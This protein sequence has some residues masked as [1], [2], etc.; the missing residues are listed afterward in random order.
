VGG[1]LVQILLFFV[2]VA[3][4]GVCTVALGY[5]L[6]TVEERVISRRCCAPNETRLRRKV[7]IQRVRCRLKG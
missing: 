6:S 2:F 3:V 5:V 4:V 1:D 7:R